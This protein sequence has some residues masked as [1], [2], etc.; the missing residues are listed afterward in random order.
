MI[1]KEPLRSG[2]VGAFAIRMDGDTLLSLN[3]DIRLVPASNMKLITT[4]VALK[5]LGPAFRFETSLAH[6]GTVER[7]VLKGDLYIIGGGDPTTGSR[8]DCAE[9]TDSLFGRWRRILLDAGIVRVEG[10]IVADQR[11][12][13]GLSENLSVCFEDLGYD[14]GAAPSGLNFFENIQTFRIA[15][16]PTPGSPLNVLPSFPDTPWMK[17]SVCARTGRPG[18]EDDVVCVNSRFGPFAE[19]WGSYPAGAYR[20]TAFCSNRFGAYT[21]AY[22]LHRY[23]TNHGISISGTWAD[24]NP[25]GL[26]RTDLLSDF[27][28]PAAAPSSLTVIGVSE[29][30]LLSDI[31]T[32]TNVHSDNF[33]AETL[34][35]MVGKRMYGNA[36]ADSCSIAVGEVLRSMGLNP[37][38]VQ[39]QDGSGLSRKNYV[40]A[41]FFVRFLRAMAG[42]PVF[43]EY[44]A[45][46]PVPGYDG[47]L[48]YL[49]KDTPQTVKDRIH[50]KSGSMNGVRCYSGY[51]L[52][53]DG[54]PG[55]TVVFSILT[56]NVTAPSRTVVRLTDSIILSLDAEN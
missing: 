5:K 29:S 1:G 47:T 21:L 54:N 30:P 7:G 28:H 18:T 34:F 31:A 49:M 56:N 42:G 16:G 23:L 46:L 2:I 15:P 37:D 25:S 48:R 10:N 41:S 50:M 14:Y 52:S 35:K 22:H 6:T 33:Y 4:G 17:Y 53:D 51:I 39:I 13:N 38:E 3:K 26:V 32:D 19:F 9:R 8:T 20:K 45:S 43:E 40:S 55:K 27:G 36:L 24:I 11:Y 12:F 44:L